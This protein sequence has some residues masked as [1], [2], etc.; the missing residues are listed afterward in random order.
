MPTTGADWKNLMKVTSENDVGLVARHLKDGTDVNFQHAEYLSCPIFEAIRGSG[1][2]ELVRMLIEDGNA[3]A[4]I[5]EDLTDSV[6][7]E[8]AVEER[9]HDIVDYLLQHLATQLKA[10]DAG[11]YVKTIC[12]TIP[13]DYDE[14]FLRFL[15][16][17]G[18]YV[19][20]E[21]T[22]DSTAATEE[23][24]QSLVHATGNKK[25]KVLNDNDSA[26]AADL[27]QV[28]YWITPSADNGVEDAWAKL[29]TRQEQMTSLQRT[30]VLTKSPSKQLRDQLQQGSK[31]VGFV[32]PTT[33][34][35]TSK[36]WDAVAHPFVQHP[37]SAW[38]SAVWH[39]LTTWDPVDGK[40]FNYQRTE[41]TS[42]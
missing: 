10:P 9:Q 26:A 29:R 21:S 33:S 41:E 17:L 19:L 23:L 32:D 38:P 20:I 3:D 14:D 39:L 16:G 22:N 40:I 8:V 37:R 28:H 4:Q 1:N 11:Q 25:V 18:H 36:V 34:N 31:M 42:V 24:A 15:V 7:L 6:P 2:V 5:S 27:A 13:D 30:I 35:L 12:V